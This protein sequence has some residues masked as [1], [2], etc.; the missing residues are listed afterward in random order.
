MTRSLN[1]KWKK[2]LSCTPAGRARSSNSA[3]SVCFKG[4]LTSC[5]RDKYYSGHNY[6]QHCTPSDFVSFNKL[7]SIFQNNLKI[8][9]PAGCRRP[10]GCSGSAQHCTVPTPQKNSGNWKLGNLYRLLLVRKQIQFKSLKQMAEPN[11][12]EKFISQQFT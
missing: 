10:G 7:F 9:I 8:F 12:C 1:G 5:C 6:Y 4:N 2:Y 11:I 3:G